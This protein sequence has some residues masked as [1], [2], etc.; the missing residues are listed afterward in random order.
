MDKRVEG[1][2]MSEKKTNEGKEYGEEE[3]KGG[4]ERGKIKI[5]TKKHGKHIEVNI[6]SILQGSQKVPVYKLNLD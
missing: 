4:R 3:K 5:N 2:R 6:L 1:Q